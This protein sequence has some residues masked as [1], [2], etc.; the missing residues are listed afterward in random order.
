MTGRQVFLYGLSGAYDEYRVKAHKFIKSDEFSVYTLMYY[1][2]SILEDCPDVETI[3]M[4]DNRHGL[5]RAMELA[6]HSDKT[7]DRIIFKT[8]LENDGVVVARR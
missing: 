1:I 6:V 8:L 4:I 7:E 2:D 3:Y 5:K